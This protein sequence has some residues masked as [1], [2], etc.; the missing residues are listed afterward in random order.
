MT[1]TKQTSAKGIANDAALKRFTK[2]VERLGC[3]LDAPPELVGTFS[4]EVGAEAYAA[5]VLHFPTTDQYSNLIHEFDDR[6]TGSFETW[7]DMLR[8]IHAKHLLNKP[9][10]FKVIEAMQGIPML[11]LRDWVEQEIRRQIESKFVVVSTTQGTCHL[12]KR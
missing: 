12:F 11:D 10:R 5:F 3:Y 6:Y 2:Y 9:T 8:Q 4:T 1:E 7:Q